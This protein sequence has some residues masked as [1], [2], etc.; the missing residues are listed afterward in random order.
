MSKIWIF[1]FTD[2]PP[3]YS[4]NHKRRH[5]SLAY[6]LL[7]LGNDVH[8]ILDSFSHAHKA[9]FKLPTKESNIEIDTTLV[10]SIGYKKNR[11]QA[12]NRFEYQKL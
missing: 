1:N 6:E 9:H 8:W 12:I 10:R 4:S 2:P 5:E 3:Q 7:H 11:L